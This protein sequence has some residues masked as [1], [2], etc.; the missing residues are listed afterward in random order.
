METIKIENLEIMLSDLEDE[1]KWYDAEKEC[2]KKGFRVPTIDEL[3]I[4]FENREKIGG[5][6]NGF[7]WSSTEGE[8]SD[9]RSNAF[10]MYMGER[11][12]APSEGDKDDYCCVRPVK[13]I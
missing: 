5:F 10:C 8:E 12:G 6:S 4:I 1:Y 11:G 13:S 9:F 3:A 7:Y 2:G